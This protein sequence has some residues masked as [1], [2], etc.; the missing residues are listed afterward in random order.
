MADPDPT[1]WTPT[2]LDDIVEGLLWPK[3][4]RAPGLAARPQRVMLSFFLLALVGA[5]GR[6]PMPWHAAEKATLLEAVGGAKLNAFHQI[7]QG[8]VALHPDAI[9]S[10]FAA[11][12]HDVPALILSEYPFAI[13]LLGVP[14]VLVEAVLGGA[15]ARSVAC[16]FSQEITHPW[17]R[18]LG[19]ALARWKTMVG[20]VLLPVAIIAMIALGLAGAGWVLFNGIPGP[21]LLGGLFY[22]FA[23]LLSIVAVVL[24]AVL[25]LGWPMLLPAAAC[26]GTDAIDAVQRVIAYVLARPLRLVGYLLLSAAIAIVA[27]GVVLLV[28][29]GADEFARG[30]LSL[31]AS[32]RG[33]AEITGSFSA[34]APRDESAA[35]PEPGRLAEISSWMIGLW[36][37]LLFLLAASYAISLAITLGT[38]IYLFMRQVCDGQH[39]AELWTP[40]QVEA[41]LKAAL[42]SKK[43]K[44]EPGGTPPTPG[45]A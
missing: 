14:I 33:V 5:I 45:G 26:E 17:P 13:L 36:G 23:L 9:R 43:S 24:T 7:W 20:V 21:E 6:I 3:L 42:R 4:F 16:E 12:I 19:F 39:Y 10:G 28:A 11:L 44:D 37:S 25:L 30:S 35:V 40:G 38:L 2:V 15:V 29:R 1:R 8:I 27:A 31:W 32:D 18:Q 22:G 41:T 34:D